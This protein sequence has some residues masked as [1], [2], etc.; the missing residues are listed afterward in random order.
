MSG[1]FHLHQ[2]IN[3]RTLNASNLQ[4][5]PTVRLLTVRLSVWKHIVG[6]WE[7][8]VVSIH[9]LSCGLFLSSAESGPQNSVIRPP[10]L[11]RNAGP[12]FQSPPTE[13]LHETHL[14]LFFL[15]IFFF[16]FLMWTIFKKKSLSTLFQYC[17]CFM[18]WL[19][20]PEAG[21]ISALW[22][23]ISVGSRSQFDPDQGSNSQPLHRKAKS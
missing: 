10:E 11:V 8:F 13:P 14:C 15:R 4:S 16:F 1:G 22:I 2:T 12:W 5:G 17:F 23:W 18:F 7:R 6:T 3:Y 19:F 9:R 21:G 20:G